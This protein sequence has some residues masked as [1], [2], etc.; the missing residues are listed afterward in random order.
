MGC[1]WLGLSLARQLV[2]NSHQVYGS[3]TSPDKLELLRKE[4]IAPYLISLSPKEIYGNIEG[5]L[6]HIDILIINVPPRLRGKNTESFLEKM[7]LL[8]DMVKKSLVTKVLFISSTAVY[9]DID[10]E[11]TE[12]TLPKPNTESGRQLLASEEL[13]KNMG[14]IETTILRFGGLIG[15]DRHP[16]TM[17]S[18][19]EN[20]SNGNDPINLIHQDD[21]I[22]IIS[23]I[24][25]EELWGKTF[26][27]VYPLH[28]T[29]REYY[30]SE[31]KK[32]GIP[33]PAYQD[34]T[35]EKKGKTVVSTYFDQ[36]HPIFKTSIV[37]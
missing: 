28:P 8:L 30:S 13:L 33:P 4:G 19:R 35:S 9:G 37:S 27:G 32:R 34:E 3:T 29:K 7:K 31:A 5:F 2:K 14:S 22:R 26:N 15:S 23:K 17:L 11:V 10:G 24:I 6:S 21:C 18:G 16:V 12:E 1:G 20:L 36:G 25:D